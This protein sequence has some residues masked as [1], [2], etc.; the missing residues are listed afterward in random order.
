[1]KIPSYLFGF[2]NQGIYCIENS[3]NR[4]RYIGSSKNIYSRLHSHKHKLLNGTHENCILQNSVLKHGLDNFECC[5]IEVVEYEN[6]LTIKEQYWINKILP[7]YNLT[8]EVIRNILSEESRIKISNTLKE[9]YLSGRILATKTSPIDMY[10]LDG[11]YI[12]S[13]HTIRGCEKDTGV[14]CSGIIRVL[15]KQYQQCKGYQFKYSW[16]NATEI[17]AIAKSKYLRRKKKNA[18]I[19][20]DKFRE[21]PAVDN[22]EP[23]L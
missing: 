21:T 4:K 17:K 20:L 7:E 2:K 19:K 23:S 11:N 18:D 12:R 16:D 9:G 8:K 10:D 1:M 15:N 22:P 14:H 6:L 5:L 13:Y 3:I